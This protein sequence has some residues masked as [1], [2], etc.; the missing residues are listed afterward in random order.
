M[1][2]IVTGSRAWPQPSKVHFELGLLFCQH[3]P[4]TLVHGACATGADA[5]AHHWYEVA[6]QTLGCI[7]IRFPA[8]WE[9]FGK[10]AGP[11][12]NAEMV[13][14]GA[15]LV[16]AFFSGDSRGTRHTVSLAEEAGIQVRSVVV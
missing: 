4:F 5:A 13:K 9:Q 15:D 16:L 1:R 7:E 10:R 2:V 14:A 3:G 11:I 12:R 8:D 6:G